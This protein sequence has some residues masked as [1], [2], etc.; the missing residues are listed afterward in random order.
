[1]LQLT[2]QI[3]SFLAV[4]FQ[5]LTNHFRRV[6]LRDWSGHWQTLAFRLVTQVENLVLQNHQR[7]KRDLHA[8]PGF[9]IPRERSDTAI[10]ILQRAFGEVWLAS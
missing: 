9:A 6:V 4:V 10:S 8:N 3:D 5:E 7:S 2:H 1:M